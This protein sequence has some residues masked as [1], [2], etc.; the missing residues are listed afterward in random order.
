MTYKNYLGNKRT[1][2][3][4]SIS[5]SIKDYLER[6]QKSMFKKTKDERFKN[7][8]VLIN[9]ILEIC[10]RFF[11]TGNNLDELES[12]IKVPKKEV[13][14]FFN[15]LLVKVNPHQYEESIELDK[16]RPI[17][18]LILN[19]YMIY[20]NFA[21][22]NFKLENFSNEEA[23]RFLKLIAKFLIQNKLTERFDVYSQDK[24]IIIEYRGFYT[25]IHYIYS[26]GLAGLMGYFG[27]ELN[28]FYYEDKY[29][30]FNFKIT[31]L[32]RYKEFLIK[33]RKA[34]CDY[35]VNKFIS[36]DQ[37]L[38]DKKSHL[39]VALLEIDNSIISFKDYDSGKKIILDHLSKIENIDNKDKLDKNSY[40][41]RN[42]LKLFS[43]L[44]WIS[45]ID[46]ETLEYHFNII[47]E[48][49]PVEYQIMKDI[50]EKLDIL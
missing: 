32:L 14:N 39:W 4:I 40:F 3:S 12:I 48:K 47:E 38:K 30:Q 2:L 25:N 35:N 29:T 9:N 21:L 46:I 22:G 23:I 13:S 11:S 42:T 41:I 43:F 49:H 8:S 26:K 36:V 50:F 1:T 34:L 24:N 19:S 20:R 16:Y 44:N 6:Y 27:L 5:R 7:I 33:Q 31:P 10:V 37:M 15:E 18:K 17:G 45:I 28:S